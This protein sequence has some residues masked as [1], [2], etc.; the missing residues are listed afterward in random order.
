MPKE[1]WSLLIDIEGFSA[2]WEVE[3]QVLWSLGQLL[4]GAVLVGR[5]FYPREPD[6]LFA[7]QIGDGVLIVSDFYEESLER[8]VC[9][10]ISLLRHVGASG[11]F[12]RA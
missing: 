4:E 2:L 3:E 1:S 11:R 9:I 6:R 12:A 5:E 8:A 7:H 10:A